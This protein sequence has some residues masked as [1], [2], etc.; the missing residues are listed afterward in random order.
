MKK[1]LCQIFAIVMVAS[2]SH[3]GPL[4]WRGAKA[5]PGGKPILMVGIGYTTIDKSWNS[6]NEEWDD[7]PDSLQT[8]VINAHFMLGYAPIDKWEIMAHVPVMNK[9]QGDLSSL[10]LQ[11]IWVKTRYNFLGGKDQPFLTGVAAVRI[12]MA[13][14]NADIVLDDRTFDIAAGALFM[15]NTAPLVFH[16]KAGYWYNMKNDADVDI[17]DEIE[18]IFKI[19]YVFNKQI[20]AFLNFSFLEGFKNK[21]AD[22]TESGGK[23]RL[24][25][26]PGIVAKPIPGLSIRPKFIFPIP[27]TAVNQLGSN[28]TWKIGLD[29]WFVPK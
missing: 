16:L 22:G 2:M 15:Y 10:G 25:V 4:L 18:A 23:R 28:F 21:A 14:E 13:D 27:V 19:D 29:I 20:K 6:T 5:M 12:P 26:I 7:K 17:G 3:A 9:S 24:N 11:D 8:T 1:I